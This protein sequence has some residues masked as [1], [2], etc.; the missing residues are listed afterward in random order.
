MWFV[1]VLAGNQYWV[2]WKYCP[3]TEEEPKA[4]RL[5]EATTEPSFESR[6]SEDESDSSETTAPL[7]YTPVSVKD[8]EF[9]VGED[10]IH[11]S[12]SERHDFT[13]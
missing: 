12:F 9:S 1:H 5:S 2:D 4:G 13:K 6:E 8:G 11:W 10:A 3:L 7:G